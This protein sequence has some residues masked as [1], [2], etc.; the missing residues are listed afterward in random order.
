MFSMQE[1][2]DFLKETPELVGDDENDPAFMTGVIIL[3][4]VGRRKDTFNTTRMLGYPEDFVT[5]VRKN[6]TR[7]GI[8]NNRDEKMT[9]L[10]ATPDEDPARFCLAFVLAVMVGMGR[11]DMVPAA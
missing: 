7:A 9:F 6:L 4:R 1:A 5:S 8:W 3:T 2:I 10:A 11:V